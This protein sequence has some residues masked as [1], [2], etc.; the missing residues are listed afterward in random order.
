MLWNIFIWAFPIV[1]IFV[2]S[3]L[4]GKQQDNNR[5]LAMLVALIAVA[6]VFF[7]WDVALTKHNFWIYCGAV[8]E[9]IFAVANVLG[10][11]GTKD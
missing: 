8:I 11:L 9:S 1:G 7:C 2:A 10:A 4:Q 6:C 3:I 5:G